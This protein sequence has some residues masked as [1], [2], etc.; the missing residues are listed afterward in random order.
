[1]TFISR[2]RIPKDIEVKLKNLLGKFTE[3][4]TQELENLV[5]NL[6]KIKKKKRKE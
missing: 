1:M 4:L 5:F 2:K 3:S 6:I